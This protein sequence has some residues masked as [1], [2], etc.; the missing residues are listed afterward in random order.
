VQA[1]KKFPA[2]SQEPS[3]GPYPESVNAVVVIIIEITVIT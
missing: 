1:L 3:A 2:F